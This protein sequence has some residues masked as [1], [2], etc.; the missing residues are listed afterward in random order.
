MPLKDTEVREI[1]RQHVAGT[2]QAAL[3]ERFSVTTQTIGR[4][5]R[6]EI[7][8]RA[9]KRE[10]L[11]ARTETRPAGRHPEGYLVAAATEYVLAHLAS[12]P[13]EP[14]RLEPIVTPS[15]RWSG[16]RWVPQ[17]PATREWTLNERVAHTISHRQGNGGAWEHASGDALSYNGQPISE[18]EAVSALTPE[19]WK[20]SNAI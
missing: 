7:G 5:L 4:V 1:R 11:L 9:A 17:K 18:E 10:T 12:F 20:A 3:A 16:G 14:H 19:Q 15:A 8:K 2:S 6:G 13:G